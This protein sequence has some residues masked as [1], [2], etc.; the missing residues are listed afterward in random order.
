VQQ[1]AADAPTGFGQVAR[2]E[3]RAIVCVEALGHP[4]R[5][6]RVAEGVQ[7]V[8]G[9]FTEGKAGADE[10]PAVIVDD[11][12]EDHLA[13]AFTRANPRAVHEV[14]DPQIVGVRH[15]VF[16]AGLARAA[17]RLVQATNLE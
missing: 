7:Q 17:Q 2:D 4:V 9:V 10:H 8:G 6:N 1:G 12:A 3:G 15:L 13:L 16:G 14:G 11:G 5:R